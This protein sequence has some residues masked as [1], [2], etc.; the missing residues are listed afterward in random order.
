MSEKEIHKQ[1]ED[2]N[3]VRDELLLLAATAIVELHSCG[4]V[5]D[6][7]RNQVYERAL[8]LQEDIKLQKP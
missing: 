3:S 5:H 2:M 7:T 1:V 8:K 6:D 4:M